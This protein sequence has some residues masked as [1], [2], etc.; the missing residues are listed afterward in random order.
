MTTTRHYFQ[1]LGVAQNYGAGFYFNNNANICWMALLR[2]P[3]TTSPPSRWNC[4][5]R[6]TG[7]SRIR[8]FFPAVSTCCG[9]ACGQ[10]SYPYGIRLTS[11]ADA[12]TTSN[13]TSATWDSIEGGTAIGGG[14]KIDTN[15]Q[16]GFA[17]E[18]GGFSLNNVLIEQP[19]GLGITIDS[20]YL[21][22]ITRSP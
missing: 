4:P 13:R 10:Q 11:S 19:S 7:A 5:A 20:R 8:A 18:V 2:R 21:G 9:T 16:T 15:D 6:V 1:G 17:G 22:G 12:N 14:I 3:R